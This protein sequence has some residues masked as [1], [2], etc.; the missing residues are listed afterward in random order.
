MKYLYMVLMLVCS[1]NS[2][3][4]VIRDDVNDQKYI[5]YAKSFNATVSFH[6]FSKKQNKYLVGGTGT[7][8]GD[9]WVI[10][11]AHVAN[12][13]KIGGK[14]EV[15]GEALIIAKV[16]KHAKWQDRHFPYDIALVQLNTKPSKLTSVKL[17]RDT[18]EIGKKVTFIGRGDY[19]NG[20]KGIL[21][22]DMKKRAAN[23][24]I[25]DA[26]EQWISFKFDQNNEA[27]ALEGISGPGDSGGPALIAVNGELFIAGISAWQ[28][29]EPTNWQEGRYGVIEHYSRISYYLNWIDNTIK[30]NSVIAAKDSKQV[31]AL[32]KRIAGRG[33]VL[34]HHVEPIYPASAKNENI[35]GSVTMSFTVDLNGSVVDIKV[36]E[37]TPMGI[38]DSAAKM[39]LSQWKYAAVNKPIKT[40]L[41]RFDFK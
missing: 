15:N 30:N 22:S 34:L 19:G 27:L 4:I 28:N 25:I 23:N 3:A 21:G 12:Y 20:L 31:T 41:T 29:A 5:D 11:A 39:A 36:E 18:K 40:V 7:L 8:I 35:T 1:F 26:K 13:L 9:R 16:I 38:F 37:S 14:V 10:T 24:T 32:K 33:R 17:Y 2:A 6:Y